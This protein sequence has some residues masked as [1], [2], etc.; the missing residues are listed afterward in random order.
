MAGFIRYLAA[1]H[2][3]G[4]DSEQ[5]KRWAE[6]RSELVASGCGRSAS[7]LA[8]LLLTAETLLTYAWSTGAV[9]P[10]TPKPCTSRP[11]PR[12]SLSTLRPAPDGSR[13]TP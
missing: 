6:I 4:E 13:S 12:W 9:P 5:R 10:K 2:E 8:H 1:R 7:H 11:T 3:A